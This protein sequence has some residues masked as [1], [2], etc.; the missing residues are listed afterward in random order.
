MNVHQLRVGHWE[1][2]E[3]YYHRIGRRPTEEPGGA[4]LRVVGGVVASAGAGAG[5]HRCRNAK[6]APTAFIISPDRGPGPRRTSRASWCYTVER[7]SRQGS[8]QCP[9]GRGAARCPRGPGPLNN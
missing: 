6:R 8:V 1:C 3:Q 7:P 5:R 4:H 9:P 2:A